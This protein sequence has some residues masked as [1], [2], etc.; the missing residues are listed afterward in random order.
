MAS[1]AT[2]E[3][4]RPVPTSVAETTGALLD[5]LF[6]P[7]GASAYLRWIGLTGPSAARST[8]VA[9]S[10]PDGS[11]AEDRNPTEVAVGTDV[12][13]TGSAAVGAA[14][15]GSAPKRRSA[16]P[17]SV[18]VR[19]GPRSAPEVP[20]ARGDVDF[21][22]SGMTAVAEGTLLETAEA[23]GLAPRNRCRRGIC[24]TCTTPKASGP[25]IDVRSGDTS[26][27]PAPVR[28]CVSVAQGDVALDL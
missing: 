9:R 1:A 14:R 11:V 5:R 3:R 20:Q 2:R 18:P 25:V 24:G 12:A 16:P 6:T 19:P 28:L 4:G 21:R 13:G 26:D 15:T 7:H 10:A 22:L 27:G 17:R 8:P 23:A